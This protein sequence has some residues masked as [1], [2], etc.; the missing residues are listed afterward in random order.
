MASM[1]S[2]WKMVVV[3]S[4]RR[5]AVQHGLF[6]GFYSAACTTVAKGRQASNSYL[7]VWERALMRRGEWGEGGRGQFGKCGLSG[8][9]C[10]F[11]IPNWE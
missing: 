3:Q 1:V 8:P 7:G 11:E 10:L 2:G 4:K 6:G 9:L 5:T